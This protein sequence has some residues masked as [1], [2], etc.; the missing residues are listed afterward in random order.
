MP[1]TATINVRV[2]DVLKT[3]AEKILRKIGIS[4]SDAITMLLHQ[5]VLHKGL[6][7]DVKIP[8]S[9]TRQATRTL[10]A[11]IRQRA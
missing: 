9:G 11:P 5:I 6:P 3:K 7:F 2:D 8:N 4:T 10:I 1:K